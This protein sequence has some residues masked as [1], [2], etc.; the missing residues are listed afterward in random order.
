M[1]GFRGPDSAVR[2]VAGGLRVGVGDALSDCLFECG[3]DRVEFLGDQ[4]TSRRADMR[5]RPDRAVCNER[6]STKF[7]LAAVVLKHHVHSDH[8]SL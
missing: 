6:R 1:D 7:P 5:E 4:F 3:L 8:R 2:T